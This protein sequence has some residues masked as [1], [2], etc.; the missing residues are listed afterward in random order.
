MR[1]SLGSLRCIPRIVS[2]MEQAEMSSVGSG[3]KGRFN[4]RDDGWGGF[5]TKTSLLCCVRRV[6]LYDDRALLLNRTA[7]SSST[8]SRIFGQNTPSAVLCTSI[9]CTAVYCWIVCMKPKG[10]LVCWF[11]DL[12]SSVVLWSVGECFCFSL[13]MCNRNETQTE[14][15]SARSS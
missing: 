1:A 11:V 15:N 6:F 13:L 4:E 9:S 2:L 14:Q 3:R 5:Q 10:L 12:V 8:A 7:Y